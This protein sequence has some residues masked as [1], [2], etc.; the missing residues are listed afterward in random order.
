MTG[1]E[2]RCGRLP[3]NAGFQLLLGE[4]LKRDYCRVTGSKA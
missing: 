3:K 4:S 2:L 1:H